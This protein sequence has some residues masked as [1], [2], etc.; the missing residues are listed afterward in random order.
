MNNLSA[1]STLAIQMEMLTQSAQSIMRLQQVQ[2]QQ[3]AQLE[4]L[5]ARIDSMVENTKYASVWQF[6]KNEGIKKKIKEIVAFDLQC[7]DLCVYLGISMGKMPDERFG[8]VHSYPV[9]VLREV[10]NSTK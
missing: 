6:V 5:N 9:E 8:S 2:S 10:L 4:E 1:P 3:N 7:H